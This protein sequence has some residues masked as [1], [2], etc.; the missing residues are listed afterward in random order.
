MKNEDEGPRAKADYENFRKVL[1]SRE[2]AKEKENTER[3][4]RISR[5]KD[6]GDN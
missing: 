5:L 6:T 4:K 2:T 1:E 3:I